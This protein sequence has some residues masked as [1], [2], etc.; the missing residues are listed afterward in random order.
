[1][2][3]VTI[4]ISSQS[5][6][7]VTF[8]RLAPLRESIAQNYYTHRWG[9][10]THISVLFQIICARCTCDSVCYE[11]TTHTHRHTWPRR[12]MNFRFT[13]AARQTLVEW[14]VCA[15]PIAIAWYVRFYVAFARSVSMPHHCRWA[16]I[17]FSLDRSSV[18]GL[19]TQVF[20][21]IQFISSARAIG[22]CSRICSPQSATKPVARNSNESVCMRVTFSKLL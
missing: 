12:E 2:T 10:Y 11:H 1:M 13:G 19:C 5:S 18:E 22:I 16:I 8:E 17:M 20:N 15:P 3:R 6:A 21:S 7:R 9:S 4:I 14:K